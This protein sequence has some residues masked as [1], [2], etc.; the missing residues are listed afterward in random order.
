MMNSRVQ[1]SLVVSFVTSLALLAVAANAN[2]QA[3]VFD[4]LKC[5]AVQKDP[6]SLQVVDGL[7]LTPEQ[8]EDFAAQTGCRV[9]DADA[10]QVCVPVAASPSHSSGGEDLNTDY[11]CYKLRCD[12]PASNEPILV[13]VTDRFGSG[14]LQVRQRPGDSSQTLCVPSRYHCRDLSPEAL[15]FNDGFNRSDSTE[16]S[17]SWAEATGDL[18]IAG[19]ALVSD[20]GGESIA[21]VGGIS[22]ASANVQ[23]TFSLAS[24]TTDASAGLLLRATGT[25]DTKCPTSYVG[26]IRKT[27]ST[28]RAEIVKTMDCAAST[29]AS[30]EVAS[31]TG[32]LRFVASGSSLT[33]SIDG[34]S[35]AT[36]SDSSIAVGTIGVLASGNGVSL[37]DFSGSL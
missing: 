17:D 16:I 30:E 11:V 32:T 18:A 21:V 20:F 4:H 35:V 6:R 5:S 24:A 19:N 26:R 9:R 23:A 3:A 1:S 31:S 15:P 22:A 33:L 36:A 34:V 37:D 12:P 28:Y 2:G 7:A 29:L 25:C 14:E 27:G 10:Y 8:I 13:D